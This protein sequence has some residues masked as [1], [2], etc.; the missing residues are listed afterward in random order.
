MWWCAVS[1]NGNEAHGLSFSAGSLTLDCVCDTEM[2]ATSFQL[3]CFSYWKWAECVAPQAAVMEKAT[4]S[5]VS[6]PRE[7]MEDP[8][9]VWPHQ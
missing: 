2:I 1:K 7:A 5:L 9:M 8:L 3:L 6:L 4:R